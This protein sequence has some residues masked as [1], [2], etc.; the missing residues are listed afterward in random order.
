MED[1][2][3]LGVLCKDS[4]DG[5][6]F[7][8]SAPLRFL[9]SHKDKLCRIATSY[10]REVYVKTLLDCGVQCNPVL[11][12]QIIILY[13]LSSPE[14]RQGSTRVQGHVPSL[15][16]VAHDGVLC[17]VSNISAT[18]RGKRRG[19]SWQAEWTIH[20][21]QYHT[22]LGHSPSPSQGAAVLGQPSSLRPP[23]P[24]RTPADYS[25]CCFHNFCLFF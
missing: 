22:L 18:D 5:I 14:R 15:R 24:Q 21:V 20:H 8:A 12:P 6:S 11:P 25:Q 13:L 16:D 19:P 23:P 3:Q 10:F 9:F 1:N 4:R 2:W 17:T 7:T